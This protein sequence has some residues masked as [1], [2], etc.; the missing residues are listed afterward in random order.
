M[1]TRDDLYKFFDLQIKENTEKQKLL[2]E[3]DLDTRI[4]ERKAIKDLI[5][6][7]NVKEHSSEG[8]IY[9][10]HVEENVSDFKDGETVCLCK[11]ES[12]RV[13]CECNIHDF[14]E[15]GDIEI[16]VNPYNYTSELDSLGN[17]KL[18][19]QAKPANMMSFYSNFCN[20]SKFYEDGYFENHLFNN[21][22]APKL[23]PFVDNERDTT[24]QVCEEDFGVKLNSNQ[25]EAFIHAEHAEDYFLIQG[26]PGSGKSFLSS[27]ILLYLFASQ[28]KRIVVVGPTHMAINNALVKIAEAFLRVCSANDAGKNLVKNCMLKVGQSYNAKG[29]FVTA[30]DGEV[31]KIANHNNAPVGLLN[32]FCD[33]DGVALPWIV[34]M[35]SYSLQSK[36]ARGLKY[37]ILF[38]DEAGQLTIPIAWMAMVEPTKV[39]LAGDHKQL[40]PIVYEKNEKEEFKH[41]IFEHLIDANNSI[42]LNVSFRMN[43]VICDLVSN[44]FYEGKLKPFNSEKRLKTN[45]TEPLY[46]AAHPIVLYNVKHK[47][48]QFSQEEAEMVIEIVTKYISSGVNPT[49]IAVLAPFRAQ[50]ALIR[51]MLASQDNIAP[52]LRKEI[53]IDTVDRMQGQEREIIIYSFT[54]G[55]PSYMADKQ[56][57]LYNPNKLNVAFSRAKNKLILL[58]NKEALAELSNPLINDILNCKSIH[59]L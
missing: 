33:D 47:S 58:A 10:L 49:D 32:N 21:H 28:K 38:V 15:C 8:T 3:M 24:R 48:K 55:D 42:M 19:L 27:L 29:L 43:G 4:A 23:T 30:P 17:C 9:L 22:K 59:N 35:T 18:Y 51:R 26:P 14:R 12:N 16:V 44:L 53:V 41:S 37:D 56:D 57:F 1:I 31:I 36:R 46:G 40:P 25:I 5:L 45:L 7:P 50:C 11:Q 20:N 13:I 52:E 54:S 34:G 39:I 6:D 2:D